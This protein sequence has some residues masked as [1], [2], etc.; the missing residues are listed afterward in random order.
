MNKNNLLEI[1]PMLKKRFFSYIDNI[2]YL[3]EHMNNM[4]EGNDLPGTVKE[5]KLWLKKVNIWSPMKVDK[6]QINYMNSILVP[7]GYKTAAKILCKTTRFKHF[8]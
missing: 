6:K 7:S 1:Y 2:E 8:K 3:I 5:I 4:D